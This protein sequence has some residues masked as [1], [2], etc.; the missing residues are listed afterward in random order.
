MR[1]GRWLL[2]LWFVVGAVWILPI[3]Y[4]SRNAVFFPLWP[5][6]VYLAV[7]VA[8]LLLALVLSLLRARRRSA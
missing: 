6:V 2:A 5:V 8:L 4:L 3:L 1:S 7:A